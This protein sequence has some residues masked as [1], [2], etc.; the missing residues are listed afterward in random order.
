MSA[1]VDALFFGII[2][3]AILIFMPGG[4]SGWIDR[5]LYFGRKVFVRADG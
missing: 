4:L 3:I 1:Q 2:I 5:F